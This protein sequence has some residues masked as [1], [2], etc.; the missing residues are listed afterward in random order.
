MTPIEQAANMA[1]E[2]LVAWMH[3]HKKDLMIQQ[4]TMQ[5][6]FIDSNHETHVLGVLLGD[7]AHVEARQAAIRQTVAPHVSMN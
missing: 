5:V 3:E 6:R 7:P 4:V 1:G 2:G